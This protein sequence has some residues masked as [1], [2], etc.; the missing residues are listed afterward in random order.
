VGV[1]RRPCLPELDPAAAL[2][3]A[4]DLALDA[5]YVTVGFWVL[6]I[7]RVQVRRRELEKALGGRV[8]LPRP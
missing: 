1:A 4:A 6:T 7:Q 8:R 3:R 5:T 2:D